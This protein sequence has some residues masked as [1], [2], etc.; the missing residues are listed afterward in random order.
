VPD[1]VRHLAFDLT[2]S[3]LAEQEKRPAPWPKSPPPGFGVSGK[4]GDDS[5]D[6]K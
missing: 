6:K 2:R 4:R 1:S 3:S 5:S